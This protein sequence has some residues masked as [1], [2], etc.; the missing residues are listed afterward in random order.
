MRWIVGYALWAFVSAV[1]AHAQSPAESSAAALTTRGRSIEAILESVLF[2]EQDAERAIMLVIDPSRSLRN[3][4]FAT[5]FAKVLRTNKSQ[6]LRLGV[7]IIGAKKGDKPLPPGSDFNDV[8]KR[9]FDAF[10]NARNV[11]RDVYSPLR[12]V[13]P[14]FARERGQRTI[15]LVAHQNGDAEY[16]LEKVIAALKK[17]KIRVVVITREVLLSD[18]YWYRKAW[19]PTTKPPVGAYRGGS[20]GA[21][22]DVP[23]GW[24]HQDSRLTSVAGSGFA[25]WGLSRLASATGGR[26]EI[27]YTTPPSRHICGGH[28]FCRFCD[29]GDHDPPTQ[30]LL[31]IR[32]KVVEPSLEARRLVCKRAASDPYYKSVLR[33]WSAAYKAGL[34]V[35][36]PAMR[37]GGGTLVQDWDRTRLYPS[38][39]MSRVS[40][41]KREAYEAKL[42]ARTANKIAARLRKAIAVGD[43]TGRG[44]DRY[45]AIAELTYVMLR[46]TRLNLLYL[47]EFLRDVAPRYVKQEPVEPPEVATRRINKDV[48]GYHISWSTIPLCHGVDPFFHLRLPGG[49]GLD[50]ELRA[51]AIDYQTFL[52]RNAH[53]PF[54]VALSHMG[55]AR[56]TLVTLGKG[57]VKGSTGPA[58]QN[59]SSGKKQNTSTAKERERERGERDGGK[60]GGGSGTP[61]S[62]G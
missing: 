53:T 9:V 15:I 34:I 57:N 47:R 59:P 11:L 13:A 27:I 52:K 28:L 60:S 3:A 58:R 33:A 61:T 10:G 31:A 18:A 7:A 32:L 35:E 30:R 29:N 22:V 43:K 38:S 23:W 41:F 6:K 25:A 42:K 46:L 8:R 21:F 5:K 16:K 36:R 48:A 20:D 54:T 50:V 12:K 1:P 62:G 19:F 26:V 44:S 49:N 37:R 17:S 45:R 2:P 56:Y 55:I 24:V 39:Y 51:F 40:D 14:L 4:Q